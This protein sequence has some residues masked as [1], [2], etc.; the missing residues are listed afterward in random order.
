LRERKL[1][2]WFGSR[3]EILRAHAALLGVGMLRLRGIVLWT[4][5]LPSA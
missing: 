1:W 2:K 5:S 4:I 3:G